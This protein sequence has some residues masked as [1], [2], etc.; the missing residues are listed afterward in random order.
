V[1]HS[2]HGAVLP[3]TTRAVRRCAVA[4]G[5][6]AV[7]AAAAPGNPVYVREW[8]SEGTGAGQLEG[9]RGIAVDPSGMLFVADSRN[10]RVVKFDSTGALL[11]S[12]GTLGTGPGQF[13]YPT[14][15]EAD[16]SGHI[17]VV[18]ADNH[19]LQKFT[20]QGQYLLE[21]DG[22]QDAPFIRIFAVGV[23]PDDTIYVSDNFDG[24]IQHYNND[25]AFLGRWGT[26]GAG[27]GQFTAA[28]G[29]TVD[30]DGNVFV[31]DVSTNYVQ[32]FSSTGELQ[33][34]WG[35]KGSAPGSFKTAFGI[36]ITPNG[37]VLVV[38]HHNFRVQRF[39]NGGTWLSMWGQKGSGPYEFAS[40]HG[41]ACD[42]RG[43]IYIL[44]FQ[45]TLACCY[46]Q[47]YVDATVGI[48]AASWSDLK[49]VYRPSSMR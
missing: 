1:F 46:I 2:C 4:L 38:D 15:V 45:G 8:G 18:D 10:N 22:T 35:G 49:R 32:K 37:D 43:Q 28:L 44:D 19:R 23:G 36:T 7:A 14:D 21:W 11:G 26:T 13:S 27:P 34:R 20:T 3:R 41:M 48:R 25:G 42:A 39:T 16:H 29:I 17:F 6:T 33:A 9:P 5:M 47:K 40:S 30:H 24:S 12:W 31:S